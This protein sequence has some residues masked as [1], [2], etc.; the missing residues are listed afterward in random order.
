MPQERLPALPRS[1]RRTRC[2]RR[3]LVGGRRARHGATP[4]PI[5]TV[6][7]L[8]L[9]LN[10]LRAPIHADAPLLLVAAGRLAVVKPPTPATQEVLVDWYLAGA[11]DGVRGAMKIV[12]DEIMSFGWYPIARRVGGEVWLRRQMYSEAT[13]R[14]IKTV[15][16]VLERSGYVEMGKIDEPSRDLWWTWAKSTDTERR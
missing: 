13:A 3:G 6:F 15:R 4:T 11:T 8:P 7:A 16:R 14:Q 12:G 9:W 10:P 2:S 1:I 5:L